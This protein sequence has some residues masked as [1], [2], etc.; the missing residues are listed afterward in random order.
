[1]L[2]MADSAFQL[3]YSC[4]LPRIESAILDRDSEE[5]ADI[6]YFEFSKDVTMKA[7]SCRVS[8]ESIQFFSGIKP[9]QYYYG[10]R[11]YNFQIFKS[12]EEK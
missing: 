8:F 11:E 2:C 3:S 4:N 7:F 9:A 6:F 10:E 5:V 12:E 1:M